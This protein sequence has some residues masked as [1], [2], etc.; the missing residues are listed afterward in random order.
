MVIKNSDLNQNLGPPTQLATISKIPP[1]TITPA[2]N[3]SK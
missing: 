3:T 1:P 2:A